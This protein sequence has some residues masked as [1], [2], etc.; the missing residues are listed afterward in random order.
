MISYIGYFYYRC[1]RIFFYTGCK[2]INHSPPQHDVPSLLCKHQLHLH[3]CTQLHRQPLQECLKPT[4][5]VKS[6][7][8]QMAYNGLRVCL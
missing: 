6:H 7:C 5:I 8:K 4:V 3:H 1:K 2:I